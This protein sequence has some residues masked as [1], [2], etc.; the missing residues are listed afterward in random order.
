M[1]KKQWMYCVTDDA[2]SVHDHDG[3][4][5]TTSKDETMP[6][7]YPKM[8]E[9]A[10]SFPTLQKAPIEPFDPE[11]LDPWLLSG[12]ACHGA[13]HAGRFILTVWSG[14]MGHVEDSKR[15]KDEMFDY[16]V[17]SPW[18]CGLFDLID[19]MSTWDDAHRKAFVAWARDP[20][21]P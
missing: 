2:V 11:V 19:A 7:H 9:L 12:A 4:R 18:A 8:T 16:R 13:L 3:K 21:W 5:S 15:N 1:T 20:W 14:R 10:A 6:N 17:E